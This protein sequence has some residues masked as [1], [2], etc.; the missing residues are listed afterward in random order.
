MKYD[1]YSHLFGVKNPVVLAANKSQFWLL[2]TVTVYHI[3]FFS[4]F[5]AE[6]HHGSPERVVRVG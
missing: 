5:Q 2:L 4:K 3:P 1:L 6:R